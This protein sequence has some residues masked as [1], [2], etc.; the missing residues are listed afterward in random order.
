MG[1]AALHAY[2]YIY[3][4]GEAQI[5]PVPGALLYCRSEYA[6]APAHSVDCGPPRRLTTGMPKSDKRERVTALCAAFPG[7]EQEQK[8]DHA[9]FQNELYGGTYHAITTELPRFGIDYTMV[10]P[11]D[12]TNFERAIRPETRLIYIETPSNPTLKITNIKAVAD[13]AKKHGIIT[14]IDNTFA[15]PVNQN[16]I[17]FG[18]DIVAHSGTKYIGGHSD[19]C[20]GIVITSKK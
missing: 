19:I 15:S 5:L 4:R 13:I 6:S 3:E 12:P 14:I 17:N 1:P 16:P 18:I 10:E 8:G 2:W 11:S 20:C 7:A 9:I